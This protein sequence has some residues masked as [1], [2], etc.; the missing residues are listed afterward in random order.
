MA[1]SSREK[2]RPFSS[3]GGEGAGMGRSLSLVDLRSPAGTIFRAPGRQNRRFS[4][5]VPMTI[6]KSLFIDS[7][8]ALCS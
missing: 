6:D 1:S 2:A 8:T 4:S 3:G 7:Q 5:S